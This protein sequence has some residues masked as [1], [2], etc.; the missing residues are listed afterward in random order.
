MSLLSLFTNFSPIISNQ[1]DFTTAGTY[2]FTVP[3]GIT[4]I[5]VVCIGGGGG[6]F[7]Q[8]NAGGGG[9]GASRGVEGGD[10]PPVRGDGGR[11]D[12]GSGGRDE[13]RTDQNGQPGAE[14]PDGE[15]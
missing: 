7:N 12:R 11:D 6:G 10:E 4:S 14:R 8:R 1:Q 15:V 5:S 13:L 2:N 3:V 9:A